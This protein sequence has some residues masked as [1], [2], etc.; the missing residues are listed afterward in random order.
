MEEAYDSYFVQ[1]W[2]A[3]AI[4]G[5]S[6]LQ[7]MTVVMR[8]LAYGVS[9]NF[10]D[11]YMQIGENTGIESLNTFTNAIV[12][13][14]GDEYLKSLINEDTARLLAIGNQRGFPGMLGSIDYMHYK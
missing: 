5:L 11:D 14:F 7:K 1:R 2:D 3:A 13:I 6:L 8:M 4:V 10:V 12:V 9:T